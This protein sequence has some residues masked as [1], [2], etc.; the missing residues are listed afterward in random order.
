MR[1]NKAKEVAQSE[2][3]LFYRPV[4]R[5]SVGTDSCVTRPHQRHILPGN[6]ARHV[7]NPRPEEGAKVS[8]ARKPLHAEKYYTLGGTVVENV[9]DIE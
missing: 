1:G 9:I 4:Q 5:T 8:L 2:E 7:S 3:S 6:N